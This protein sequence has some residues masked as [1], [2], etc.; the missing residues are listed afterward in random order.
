MDDHKHSLSV[1]ATIMSCTVIGEHLIIIFE[2][3]KVTIAT[4][5]TANNTFNFIFKVL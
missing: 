1:D 4:L 5:C 2:T 3:Q